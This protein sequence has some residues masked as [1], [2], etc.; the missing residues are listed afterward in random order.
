MI[1]L[2]G[3]VGT[4]QPNHPEDVKVVQGLLNKHTHV[5]HEHLIEDRFCG[6][7]T[8]AAIRTF[9]RKV[10]VMRLPDGIVSNHGVTL[11]H[12]QKSS[13][14]PTMAP[15]PVPPS[16][17]ARS[18]VLTE[19]DY[20]RAAAALGCEVAAIKA[21]AIVERSH[22]PFDSEG[23]PTIL[24]ERHHFSRLTKHIYHRTHPEISSRKGY[25][26]GGY[27]TDA[28]QYTKLEAAYKLNQDAALMATSWGEFQILGENYKE[29]GFQSV[30][31]FVA[32]MRNSVG[33]H[34]TAF[35]NY[36]GADHRTKKAIQQKDWT[37][38]A[39]LCNG[40]G[41][42]DFHYDTRLETAY[43]KSSK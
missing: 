29:A 15:P 39:R 19:D 7:M 26:R 5:T 31:A 17:G 9:Q 42:K 27:G 12:L 41:Y 8:E 21:V 10:L 38:F 35:V 22:G 24:Y 28:S 16:S 20:K 18:S 36:V 25:G 30:N 4:H 23:R 13:I 43:A 2:L 37:T 6:H 33:D 34:L 40:P 11:A 3:S 1:I 14:W 32:S